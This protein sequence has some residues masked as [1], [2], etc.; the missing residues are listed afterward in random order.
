[1]SIVYAKKGAARPV[2]SIFEL[3]FDNIKDD[4][5]SVFVIVSYDSIMSIS[6]ITS[7]NASLFAG[8]F[9]RVVGGDEVIKLVLFHFYVFLLLLKG[10]DEPS[11]GNK[12]ILACCLNILFSRAWLVYFIKSRNWWL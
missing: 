7:D 10:H 3:W 5:Y 2:F 8:K 12:L 4:W 6:W 1:M 11:V 9:C